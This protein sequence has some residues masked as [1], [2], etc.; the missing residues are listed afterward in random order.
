MPC[1]RAAALRP[2]ASL[3]TTVLRRQV[4]PPDAICAPC[5]DDTPASLKP[6]KF[7]SYEMWDVGTPCVNEGY[8][9]AQ[10]V[11]LGAWAMRRVKDVSDDWYLAGR[12]LRC[13]ECQRR[14]AELKAELKEQK[15][16]LEQVRSHT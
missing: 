3:I 15:E 7:W 14:K 8:E 6:I 4:Y 10:H 11:T 13:S 2:V 16:E 1:S 12:Q 5:D 9:H